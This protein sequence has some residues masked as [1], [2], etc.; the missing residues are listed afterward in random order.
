MHRLLAGALALSLL[1]CS[2]WA[3]RAPAA[4]QDA[5]RRVEDGIIA[6]GAA[7]QTP[8]SHPVPPPS[9]A[10]TANQRAQSF[11]IAHPAAR[12]LLSSL[13]LLQADYG[14]LPEA[15][16]AVQFV[17]RRLAALLPDVPSED[18]PPVQILA[19]T[20]FGINAVMFAN[21]TMVLSPEMAQFCE[22]AEEIDGVLMHEL[23]H[24]VRKHHAFLAKSARDG[25]IL[26]SLG[27][28]R[29][30]EYEADLRAFYQMAEP[31]RHTNPR[32]ITRLL[33]RLRDEERTSPARRRRISWDV[34]HGS[35]T[36]LILNLKI[37]TR[38]LDFLHLDR[39]LTP[40]DP[41]LSQSLAGLP[42]GGRLTQ[43]LTE[44]PAENRQQEYAWEREIAHLLEHAEWPLLQAAIEPLYGRVRELARTASTRALMPSELSRRDASAQLLRRVVA[45]WARL[46][47]PAFHLSDAHDRALLSVVLLE[48]GAG[49]PV[50]SDPADPALAIVGGPLR[51]IAQAFQAPRPGYSLLPA[52][53]SL[54]SRDGARLPLDPSRLG[55]LLAW[56]A[57]EALGPRAEYD[58]AEGINVPRY[59]RD[60]AAMSRAAEGL[61]S[62]G[63]A[64][65]AADAQDE[66]EDEVLAET[67]GGW[68]AEDVWT[69]AVI[70]GALIL[71]DVEEWARWQPRYEQLIHT[72][73]PLAIAPDRIST[74]LGDYAQRYPARAELARAVEA[75]ARAQ[76]VLPLSLQQTI[77]RL[78]DVLLTLLRESQQNP[79][80]YTHPTHAALLKE[81]GRLLYALPPEMNPDGFDEELVSRILVG[82][83]GKK[84]VERTGLIE[85][86]AIGSTGE[87]KSFFHNA[88]S[89]DELLTAIAWMRAMAPDEAT[90]K[91][92]LTVIGELVPEQLAASP[93]EL[94][95]L[96]RTVREAQRAEAIAGF[97]PRLRESEVRLTRLQEWQWHALEALAKQ[98]E[99]LT[100]ADAFFQQLEAFL[101]VWPVASAI[102]EGTGNYLAHITK[103]KHAIVERALTFLQPAPNGTPPTAAT[104]KRLLIAGFF[105]DD[106]IIKR[107]VQDYALTSLVSAL[108]LEEAIQLLVRDFGPQGL[109]GGLRTLELLDEKARTPEELARLKDAGREWL[110]Q[111]GDPLAGM[112]K[113]VLAEGAMEYLFDQA[114]RLPMVLALLTS[115]RDESRLRKV[116]ANG[117]WEVYGDNIRK[118]IRSSLGDLQRVD[119]LAAWATHPPRLLQDKLATAE[120]GEKEKGNILRFYALQ[121]VLESVYRL[122][123]AERYV[124][125][126]KLLSGERGALAMQAG[127]R[128]LLDDFFTTYVAAEADPAVVALMREVFGALF[129]AAPADELY[130]TLEPLLSPRL[131]NPPLQPG[132][133]E[134][135]ADRFAE[136]LVERE[137]SPIPADLWEKVDALAERRGR[138][139]SEVAKKKLVPPIQTWLLSLMNGY[140]PGHTPQPGAEE[141][142]LR[143]VPHA[144]LA[145]KAEVLSPLALVVDTARRLGAP[146]VRF[147]QLLGQT[148]PIPASYREEFLTVYDSI[149]GQTTL[150]AWETIRRELPDYATRVRTIRRIGGGSLMTVYK[151][152]LADGSI[153]AV[154]VLNPNAWYH[155]QISLKIIR[156][157]LEQL[158]AQDKKYARAMPLLSLIERWIQQELDDPAYDGDDASF[159]QAWN[160]WQPTGFTAR[161]MIPHNIPTGT[162]HVRREQFVPGENFTK[163]DQF[164]P[165][166]QKELAALAA[167]HYVAQIMR[168]QAHSD[169]SPGNV[170]RGEDGNLVILDRGMYLN[171]DAAEQMLL[172]QLNQA[173][174]PA[175]RAEMLVRWL[176]TLPDN[177][178]RAHRRKVEP[179]LRR[180]AARLPPQGSRGDIRGSDHSATDPEE[181]MLNI[182]VA[183]H[184]EGLRVPLKFTLL[185]KNLNVLH[186]FAKQAGFVSL[187]EA[188]AYRPGPPSPS[189]LSSDLAGVVSSTAACAEKL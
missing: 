172:W 75:Y 18:L 140:A 102:S 114:D 65:A 110:A 81:A 176:W 80:V 156:D 79:L 28:Q 96:A 94:A 52:L 12:S 27:A 88:S 45:R 125:L 180:I 116:L 10:P 100:D 118:D 157:A 130:L 126:R 159:Y 37:A 39:D 34:A 135:A 43:L 51:E 170:R 41:A 109:L 64:S 98:L 155:A 62:N 143:L 152:E 73:S 71:A 182:L 181:A 101:R 55:P 13:F 11:A 21:G 26:R 2:A 60:A 42:R 187:A 104:L 32:G 20:G 1:P 183:V 93:E 177:T 162:K 179:A 74:L 14:F 122:G 173:A 153:E 145:R 59:L 97:A 54:L 166:Q 15:H 8:P 108:P 30:A 119:E 121:E 66:A 35:L 149:K 69:A 83:A 36:D 23:N 91:L 189:P 99:P 111:T 138:D 128:Q 95:E 19:S 48:A 158:V 5:D 134:P 168:G 164:P 188:L 113:A 115:T 76:W 72:A 77:A 178:T 123:P 154:R 151:V 25:A 57:H 131:G 4:R 160:D 147:L 61:L 67:A 133:W 40:I 9:A 127:R 87:E 84:L 3:I 56:A 141:Q 185:F 29:Y 139:T 169:V 186:R 175:A 107:Q 22:T 132:S 33:E 148:V 105:F 16:V 53:T 47:G 86:I 46:I 70:G 89:G 24:W 167:Q 184:E 163:L 137:P 50:A 112:G 17:R 82:E 90:L 165:P 161:V 146:G 63:A 44:P 103:L 144:F 49:I 120:V 171:F 78:N 117:W 85:W 38:L 106:A 129:D 58:E 92:W 124:L 136:L 68:S 31:H 7:A 6:L 174:T 150:A 142:A